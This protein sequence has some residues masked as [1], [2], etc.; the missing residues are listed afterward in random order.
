MWEFLEL[1]RYEKPL[2]ALTIAELNDK[3]AAAGCSK[4]SIDTVLNDSGGDELKRALISLIRGG[5]E[6][7]IEEL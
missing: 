2:P 6:G 7:D 3:A 4:E 1:M 5:S